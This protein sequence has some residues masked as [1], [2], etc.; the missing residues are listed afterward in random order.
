MV[1]AKQQ[2]DPRAAA[3]LKFW[4]G[5]QAVDGDNV[6]AAALAQWPAE[7]EK[8]WWRGG[9]DLDAEIKAKFGR[10]L[11]AVA[12]GELDGWEDP[13]GTNP[14]NTLAGVILMDQFSR[15]VYRGTP[16]AF[17]LDP[18][19]LSWAQ[20]LAALEEARAW[21]HSFRIWIF[22]PFEHSESLEMQERCIALFEEE[23]ARAEGGD[24]PPEAAG[25]ARSVLG[26]AHAHLAVI[27]AWGR[28]PHRNAILGREST[29]EEI[30]GMA[31][32]SIRKF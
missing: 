14:L 3:V 4:L 20:R 18:K 15:N 30:A 9:P 6:S 10:D 27:K 26:Y 8:L 32:G 11:E 7:R 28:F 31:D 16:G 22:M 24:G 12:A 21:P 29:P 5:D 13:T 1:S 17:A 23:V 2:L 25:A 19:A